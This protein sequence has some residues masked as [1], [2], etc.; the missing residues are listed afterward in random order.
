MKVVVPFR[1]GLLHPDLVEQLPGARYDEMIGDHA[2][3]ALLK[4]IIEERQKVIIVE[5]DVVPT[6]GQLLKLWD[7]PHPWCA[8]AYEPFAGRDYS[9]PTEVVGFGLCKLGPEL[10]EMMG[11]VPFPRVRWDHCDFV[12]TAFARQLGFTPHQHKGDVV[13]HL[14]RH[15]GSYP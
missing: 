14:T 15:G 9:V 1:E 12:F 7:C 10:L 13:H 6:G 8:H 2:Y 3:A 4:D 5:H 11:V